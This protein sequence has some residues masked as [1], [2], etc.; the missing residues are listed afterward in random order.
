MPASVLAETTQ[1]IEI[2]STLAASEVAFPARA[3]TRERY[4][5]LMKTRRTIQ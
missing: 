4:K 5:P 3:G 1:V 2:C